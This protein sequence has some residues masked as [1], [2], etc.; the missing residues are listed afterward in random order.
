MGLWPSIS[1]GLCATLHFPFSYLWLFP[2]LLV[3][4]LDLWVGHQQDLSPAKIVHTVLFIVLSRLHAGW[5]FLQGKGAAVSLSIVW[6]KLAPKFS[7]ISTCSLGARAR[8][9]YWSFFSVSV[10]FGFFDKKFHIRW[11]QT[12]EKQ[13]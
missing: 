2:L 12:N 8:V 5:G 10:S 11:E 4:V 6:A 3:S 9:S 13:G 1:R 7:Q